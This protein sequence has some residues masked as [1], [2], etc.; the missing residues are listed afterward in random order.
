MKNI[1]LV[2]G[3]KSP[4]HEI[5]I[6]SAR[7]ILQA[8]SREKYQITIIGIDVEGSWRLIQESDLADKIEAGRVPWVARHLMVSCKIRSRWATT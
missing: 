2:C 1:A 5:S 8:I 7:N 6:R 3:G 4:E